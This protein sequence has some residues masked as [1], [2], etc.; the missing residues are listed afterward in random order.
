MAE[1]YRKLLR[2]FVDDDPCEF[3]HHGGCQTHG[4][5]EPSPGERCPNALA[6][7]L[8]EDAPPTGRTHPMDPVKELQDLDEHLR[9]HK[10]QWEDDEALT[11]DYWTGFE[12]ARRIVGDHLGASRQRRGW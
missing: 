7:E 1:P 3:D 11:D 10:R 4:F 6:K 8:L 2:E 9:Q 5:Y 12:D